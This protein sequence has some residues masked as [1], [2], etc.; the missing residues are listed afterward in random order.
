MTPLQLTRAQRVETKTY[1]TGSRQMEC[2]FILIKL[3][4]THCGNWWLLNVTTAIKF[5][6]LLLLDVR[7]KKNLLLHLEKNT[8]QY[9]KIA[10]KNRGVCFVG[11]LVFQTPNYQGF[12]TSQTCNRLTVFTPFQT[13]RL[14]GF[15]PF[16]KWGRQNPDLP[17][18]SITGNYPCNSWPL[19]P[20]AR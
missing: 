15:W 14:F 1:G 9:C 3:L 12:H 19:W 13:F 17:G 7:W 16:P 4:F 20:F 10:K 18:T 2:A 11:L 8:L 6:V 5:L